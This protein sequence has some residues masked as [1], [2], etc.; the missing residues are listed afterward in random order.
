MYFLTSEVFM[1]LKKLLKYCV[2]IPIALIWDGL[3]F[4]CRLV[5][6]CLG[7]LNTFATDRFDQLV[8]WCDK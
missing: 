2:L 3:T 8:D 4:L 6:T 1:K 5:Y 7:T